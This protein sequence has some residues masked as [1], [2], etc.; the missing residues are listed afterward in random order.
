MT[1]HV[2]VSGVWKEITDPQVNV[3]G[4]WKNIDEAW[5]NVSGV[6]K[7]FYQ[8][9]ALQLGVTSLGDLNLSTASA[10]ITI[11]RDGDVSVTGEASVPPDALDWIDPRNST[12]GDDYEIR[13]TVNSGTT[14][15]GAATGSWIALSTDRTWSI[16]RSGDAESFSD[17][18][19]EIRKASTGEVVLTQDIEWTVISVSF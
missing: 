17:T 10:S 2:N 1:I 19:L 3:S 4:V 14:P 18:T 9:Y 11:Q 12:V 7:Q 15:A 5:V 13:L 16:T 8:R 6:W